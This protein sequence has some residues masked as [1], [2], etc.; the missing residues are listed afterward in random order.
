MTY[1]GLFNMPK[2]GVSMPRLRIALVA[3]HFAEYSVNLAVALSKHANVLLCLYQENA[4]NELGEDWPIRFKDANLEIAIINNPKSTIDVVKN[5]A[6]LVKHIKSFNPTLIHYQE[7]IRD[8]IIF[9]LPALL[10]IKKVITVHDP[11]TH[12]GRDSNSLRFSRYRLYRWFF[13]R[14]AHAAIVHGAQLG[15]QLAQICPWLRGHISVIPHGPIGYGAHGQ[16]QDIRPIEFNLLFFGRIHAYKGLGYFVDAVLKL[17]AEGLP[18]T[19]VIAGRGTD[20]DSHRKHITHSGGFEVLEQYVPAS[21]VPNLFYSAYAVVLPY[22]DGTQSGVA[23]M[24][25]QYGRPVIATDVGAIPDLVRDGINGLIVPPRDLDALVQA[26]KRVISDRT[27]HRQLSLGALQ[28]RDGDL[29]WD[30]IAFQTMR[31]YQATLRQ[32]IELA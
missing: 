29:S 7:G 12:S 27:L 26:I 6:G 23:A 11:E 16:D 5:A 25:L 28:L 21:A 30:A 18:V 32:G 14:C 2:W 1:L 19:G 22:V 8:E 24:A 20:L 13:R 17:R 31:A 3:L 10:G 9:S 4:D 15:N